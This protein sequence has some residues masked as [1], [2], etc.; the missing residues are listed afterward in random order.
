MKK[1]ITSI[2]AFFAAAVLTGCAGMP[3][4]IDGPMT[5]AKAIAYVSPLINVAPQNLKV[6]DS[7][8]RAMD[9]RFYTFRTTDG[10]SFQCVFTWTPMQGIQ[11]LPFNEQHPCGNSAHTFDYLLKSM[12]R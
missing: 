3:Q 8:Y 11:P 7:D 10:R 12:S 9:Y 5:D 6:V 1:I 4:I 2:V